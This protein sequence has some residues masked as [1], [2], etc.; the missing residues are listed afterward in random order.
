MVITRRIGRVDIIREHLG[1]V[2][3]KQRLDVIEVSRTTGSPLDICHLD[4]YEELQ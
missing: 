4:W 2:C 1:D 3:K